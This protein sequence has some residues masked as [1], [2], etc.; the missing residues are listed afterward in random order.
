MLGQAIRDFT[1]RRS[2]DRDQGL[3]TGGKV[4]TAGSRRRFCRK[5]QEP[6]RLAPESHRPLH[7]S[8]LR[9]TTRRSRKRQRSTTWFGPARVRYLGASSHAR[10]Q[11]MKA[12][13]HS[14]RQPAGR[15]S[16]RCRTTT[17]CSIAKRSARCCGCLPPEGIPGR[18]AMVK[19][20]RRGAGS[21]AGGGRGRSR[22]AVCRGRRPTRSA[23]ACSRRRPTSTNCSWTSRHRDRIN[24]QR[25]AAGC[26]WRWR[27][28][29]NSPRCSPSFRACRGPHHLEGMRHGA[30][31]RA[32]DD[33]LARLDALY[34][35]HPQS[36]AFS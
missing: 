32:S 17:T 23:P 5:G 2:R 19:P 8:P 12:T 31:A 24:S 26:R 20:C 13:R 10:W 29:R 11:F 4:P 1:R 14:A 34:R 16:S 7:R 27:V 15:R 3:G 6:E 28:L 33:E 18:D 30:V 25:R 35:P 9:P 21:R 22:I 36:E